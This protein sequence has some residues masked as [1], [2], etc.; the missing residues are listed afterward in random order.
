MFQE[1]LLQ[2]YIELNS[3]FIFGSDARFSWG[4][5][6]EVGLLDVGLTS[7]LPIIQRHVDRNRTRLPAQRQCSAQR[8]PPLVG[9]LRACGLENDL[10]IALAVE[11]FWAQ[12]RL[13]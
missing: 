9:S 7:V 11:H 5:D 8:P 1:S 10:L 13:L 4:R 12:H 3:D 2:P 6:P